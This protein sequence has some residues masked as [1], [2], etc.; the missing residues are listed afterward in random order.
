VSL[1][2]VRHCCAIGSQAE[3]FG[4]SFEVAQP[5]PTDVQTPPILLASQSTQAPPVTPQAPMTLPGVH[6][7]ERQQPPLHGWLSL[8]A[9]VH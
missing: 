3:P 1:Q 2:V 5:Q 6:I 4:Q 7:P 8:H 9:I